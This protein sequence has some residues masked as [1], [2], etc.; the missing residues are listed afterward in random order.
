MATLMADFQVQVGRTKGVLALDGEQP[1][2]RSLRRY[3]V[4]G[5]DDRPDLEAPLVVRVEP[6]AQVVL[7][8]ARVEL[9]VHA[10]GVCLPHVQHRARERVAVLVTNRAGEEEHVPRLVLAAGQF[11]GWLEFGCLLDV[12]R[13]LDRRD[14]AGASLMAVGDLIHGRLYED[15]GHEGYLAY[16]AGLV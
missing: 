15:V 14:E 2:R 5:W 16:L 7:R 3:L 12:V 10:G 4:R 6:P 9:R 13:S 1:T 8:H 11:V